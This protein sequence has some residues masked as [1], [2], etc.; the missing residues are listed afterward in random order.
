VG[1]ALS[2]LLSLLDFKITVFDDRN[3]V[4]TFMENHFAHTKKIISYDE[5][6]DYIPSGKNIMV[7][8]MTQFHTSDAKVLEQLIGKQLCYLGMMGSHSKVKTI[9]GKLREKGIP[10]HLLQ[11]VHAPIGIQI[12]SQT[13]EEIAVSIAAELIEM[14]NG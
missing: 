4:N 1:L 10:N 8:I 6:G 12:K 2:Q 14:K 9:F 11:N 3:Q 5:V 7:V 13:P